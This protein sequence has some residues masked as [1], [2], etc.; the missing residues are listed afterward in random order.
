MTE[1]NART[2][3]H[4]HRPARGGDLAGEGCSQKSSVPRLR[5]SKPAA[6]RPARLQPQPCPPPPREGG[7]AAAI[8]QWRRSAGDQ[9]LGELGPCH[10]MTATATANAKEHLP[11]SCAQ[12]R[13]LAVHILGLAPAPAPAPAPRQDMAPA[14]GHD[15]CRVHRPIAAASGTTEPPP[16]RALLQVGPFATDTEETPQA[17]RKLQPPRES[18]ARTTTATNKAVPGQSTSH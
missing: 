11:P 7:Q 14:L 13:V 16:A 8:L 9:T 10:A 15:C 6:A 5:G 4:G 17:W 18:S 1:S 2:S 12:T 3:S